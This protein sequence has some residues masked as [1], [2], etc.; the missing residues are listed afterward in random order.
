MGNKED[1]TKH[2]SGLLK[3]SFY[4]GCSRMPRCDE[5]NPAKRR[6]MGVF[7]QLGRHLFFRNA[8]DIQ[9]ILK[10]GSANTHVSRSFDFFLGIIGNAEA[11]LT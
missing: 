4:Q 8:Q 3:K 5:M 9:D 11:S 10:A 1:R 2:F 7:Q 6:H